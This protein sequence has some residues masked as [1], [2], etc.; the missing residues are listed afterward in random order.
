MVKVWDTATWEVRLDF[1]GH[2]A[3]VWAVVFSPDGKT[4]ATGDG[5]WNRGGLVKL[6]N[7][8]TG[9]ATGQHQ[10]TGEVLCIAYSPDGKH[11]A[12][13]AGDKT[14]RVWSKE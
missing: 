2:D 13:G 3:D 8:E 6:W 9:D 7:V 4:L 1:K 14:V 10:H 12:A 5:D 11:L